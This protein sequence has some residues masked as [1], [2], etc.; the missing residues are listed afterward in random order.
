MSPKNARSGASLAAVAVLCC[1][2]LAARAG[3]MDQ[4]RPEVTVEQDY[5]SNIFLVD[6]DPQGS[7]VTIIR[8]ALNFENYG[9]LGHVR[10]SGFL[11]DHMYWSESKLSGIDRGFGAD[12]ERRILPLTT[13]FG[14]GSFQRLAAHSEI[15]GADI[16]TTTG[17]SAGVPGETVIS[18]GQ[19]IEGA[20]PDVNLGQ[21]N[22]GVRQD[23][24]PRLQLQ[25]A[26]GPF[27]IDY[28]QQSGATT[29]RDRSGW[30]AGP[31]L[32]YM[33]SPLDQMTLDL[34]A[35]GTDFSDTFSQ[36]SFFVN[37]PSD[38]HSIFINT[39]KTKSDQQSLTLGWT[40]QWTE[41]LST[42][43]E[44]G[45]RRLHTRTLDALRPLTRVAPTPS[46]L[47]SFV[48]FVPEDFS[49][50][51]PGIVGQFSISRTLPRGQVALT[52]SRETRTTSS[53]FASDVNVDTVSVGFVH[54][55]TPRVTFVL[56]GYFEH[57]ASVNNNAQFFPAQ[58]Q[59]G[60]FNP[61]TGPE[62]SC[63][64]GFLVTSGTGINKTGQCRIDSRSTLT[65]DAWNAVARL[66]WQLYRRLTTFVV[67]RYGSRNGDEQLF[68]ENYDKYVAG[69]GFRI[70]YALGF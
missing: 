70:D 67:L 60:S 5:D 12:L 50:T 30:Y 52:Y 57:Y 42:T 3:E 22:F 18:P 23:L 24:T 54:R 28:L 53:L 19:L 9:T 37:D 13:I 41:L 46:G 14:T 4:L 38:P 31:T 35:T 58:Y 43:I 8:P 34:Q 25:L 65:S 51:G 56:R 16:V 45:G 21:G 62:Y 2:A 10:F 69:A 59:T 17:G 33:V 44:V 49:D 40:R 55:F 1:T 26:G 39:G 15:R 36:N 61:I 32:T 48:D 66:D 7:A 20:T 47:V 68:G 27:E 64:A 6:K 63:A 11:S 29:W